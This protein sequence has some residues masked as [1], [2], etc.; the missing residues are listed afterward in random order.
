MSREASDRS[1]I[2][3]VPSEGCSGNLRASFDLQTMKVAALECQTL[4]PQVNPLICWGLALPMMQRF[5]MEGG[6]VTVHVA[7]ASVSDGQIQGILD[8]APMPRAGHW[9][10]LC[11]AVNVAEIHPSGELPRAFRSLRS[12]GVDVALNNVV[13]ERVPFRLFMDLDFDCMYLSDL[14][15]RDGSAHAL[16]NS[17]MVPELFHRIHRSGIDIVAR[18]IHTKS[19]LDLARSL[20][21]N[22]GQGP[23]LDLQGGCVAT[24]F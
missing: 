8:S 16:V 4:S 11:L 23:H 14:I 21:C 9:G 3:D 1:L 22:Q 24:L 13:P 15:L 10:G 5:N 2:G 6:N 17:G 20:G 7:Y 12:M 18:G 19:D